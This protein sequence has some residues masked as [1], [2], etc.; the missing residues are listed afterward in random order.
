MTNKDDRRKHKKK[1]E[2]TEG[3]DWARLGYA[4]PSQA[5]LGQALASALA[6]KTEESIAIR[7][8]K[9]TQPEIS[10]INTKEEEQ[11][12]NIQE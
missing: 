1:E 2:E 10:I 7:R 6:K 11:I 9:Q 12:R 4:R 3:E 5:R 8:N